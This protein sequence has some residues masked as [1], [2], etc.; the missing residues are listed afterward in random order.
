MRSVSRPRRPDRE[1]RS[2]ES[3]HVLEHG[4]L[5][6]VVQIIKAGVQKRPGRSSNRMA[7]PPPMGT[8]SSHDFG[9]RMVSS[10]I[11]EVR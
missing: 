11:V 4:E 6:P 1:A 3:L 2:L 7:Y 8:V 10:S 9:I 5:L